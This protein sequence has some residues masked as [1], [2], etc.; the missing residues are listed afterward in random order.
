MDDK[1]ERELQQANPLFVYD[2][3]RM[4]NLSDRKYTDYSSSVIFSKTNRTENLP[5]I[6]SFIPSSLTHV[7]VNKLKCAVNTIKWTPDGRRL[8]SGTATGEFTLWNGYGFN[9]ETILQAHESAVRAMCWSPTGNFLVSGDNNGLIKYWHPSM[10][11]IQIINGHNESVRDISFAPFDTKFCTCSDDG[12]VKIWD[13]KDAREEN[14]LKGHG[15]DVRNAKWNPIKALIASG[16]KDCAVKLWDPRASEIFTLHLHKN[17]IFTVKWS[18]D[19][20]YLYTN[21]RD[22]VLKV[23]DLRTLKTFT[24]KPQG[25]DITSSAVHPFRDDMIIT[26]NSIGEINV[27][28][29]FVSNPIYTITKGHD[30]VI[31]SAEFHPLGHAFATGSLDQ[32]VR[33]W[34]KSGQ[35]MSQKSPNQTDFESNESD[36]GESSE[37]IPGL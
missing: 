32:S 3:R 12:L 14:V 15:W 23:T 30:N 2:G 16:G 21:G 34:T 22:Q 36:L 37:I 25:K 31:W 9:F 26:G 35:R 11:N 10:S 18:N 13:S 17:T 5:S 20:L 6:Y 1:N 28:Q 4:R 19:G 7:S 33:F 8:I 24:F 29:L 27:Y